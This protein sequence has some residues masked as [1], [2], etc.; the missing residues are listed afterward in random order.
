MASSILVLRLAEEAP[1]TLW[2]RP[3][4]WSRPPELC[5]RRPSRRPGHTDDI[6]KEEDTRPLIISVRASKRLRRAPWGRRRPRR[7]HN[8]CPMRQQWLLRRRISIPCLPRRPP[9]RTSAKNRG[10]SPSSRNSRP[11]SAWPW[12]GRPPRPGPGR[13]WPGTCTGI[14]RTRPGA[15]SA[16]CRVWSSARRTT[17]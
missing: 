15:P 5:R 7:R 9:R 1:E 2:S 3:H 4:S 6:D 16:A 12:T 11:A 17:T 10:G 8:M 14:R 13:S